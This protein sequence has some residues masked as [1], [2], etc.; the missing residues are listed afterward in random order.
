MSFVMSATAVAV[1]SSAPPCR[2]LIATAKSRRADVVIAVDG[3]GSWRWFR[4]R[5]G[6]RAVMRADVGGMAPPGPPRQVDD[7]V[8]ADR[9]D[10]TAG[11]AQV[12]GAAVGRCCPSASWTSATLMCRGCRR[13]RSCRSVDCAACCQSGFDNV[14]VNVRPL[15]RPRRPGRGWSRSVRALPLKIAVPWAGG[16]DESEPSRPP[17][18]LTA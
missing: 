14:T 2:L 1:P 10:G 9:P 15:P 17:V 6:V 8:S 13:R 5:G 7:I 3:D 11:A 4:R 16:A 12:K 18:P